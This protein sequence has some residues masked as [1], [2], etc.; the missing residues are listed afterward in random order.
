MND[1]QLRNLF[2]IAAGGLAVQG[3]SPKESKT[4]DE[5]KPQTEVVT[6]QVTPVDDPYGNVS[7]LLFDCWIHARCRPPLLIHKPSVIVSNPPAF[8]K[9]GEVQ[10]AKEKKRFANQSKVD[11]DLFP[12]YND[13]D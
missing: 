10:K 5:Q 1:K 3:C 13:G 11:G 9:I 2:L 4:Q 8:C 6:P 7:G 12:M